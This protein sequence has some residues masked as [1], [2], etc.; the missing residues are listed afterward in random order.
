LKKTRNKKNTLKLK[1]LDKTLVSSIN[2]SP[3]LSLRLNTE[4]S[5]WLSLYSSLESNLY[6]SLGSS[7]V[8]SL[9]QS[10]KEKRKKQ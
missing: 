7:L 4:S 1:S 5:F 2:S 9:W 10:L 3:P 8:L 6:S